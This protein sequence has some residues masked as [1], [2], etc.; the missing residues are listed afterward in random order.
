MIDSS[1]IE[2][3]KR[4][5]PAGLDIQPQAMAPMPM[6]VQDNEQGGTFAGARDLTAA[7]MDKL[8]PQRKL[9]VFKS[10]PLQNML[11]NVEASFRRGGQLDQY[12]NK[13]VLVGEEGPEVIVPKQPSTV[14]PTTALEQALTKPSPDPLPHRE[15]TEENLPQPPA[16]SW[17]PNTDTL[18]NALQGVQGPDVSRETMP[19]I[20]V[21]KA[22]K[23]PLPYGQE[24][25]EDTPSKLR[26]AVVRALQQVEKTGAI[27]GVSVGQTLASA[28]PGALAGVLNP[29]FLN[30]D[31][32][33]RNQQKEAVGLGLQK[34]RQDVIEQGVDIENKRDIPE[35][36]AEERLQK[37]RSDVYERLKLMK[38]Y[39]RGQNPA[40]DAE[41]TKA[42]IVLDDFDNRKVEHARVAPRWKENGYWKTLDEDGNVID[43]KQGDRAMVDPNDV[44]DT[45]GMTPK[46]RAMLGERAGD[47]QIQYGNKVAQAEAE[48]DGA[49]ESIQQVDL[50][51][52]GIDAAIAASTDEYEKEDLRA[53][54]R[55]LKKS[56]REALSKKAAADRL[57][58]SLP[59]PQAQTQTSGQRPQFTEAELR[60]IGKSRPGVDVEEL[61]RRARANGQLK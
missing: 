18:Q 4:R 17:L 5:R 27:P 32:R 43:L 53:E 22:P 12:L 60:E 34:R 57:I 15:A 54:R 26:A 48:R 7:L 50:E 41:L 42:G 29:E 46:D 49:I 61:V 39:K 36:R 59:K 6:P 30:N 52:R 2:A 25:L 1:L 55:E 24:H 3:L 21:G 58:G 40:F 33:A 8:A 20:D 56:R 19:Y 28:G 11:P 38:N 16:P 45:S 35:I 51:L 44:A 14:I 31:A 37:R 9:P 13:P 23:G 10:E 47:N